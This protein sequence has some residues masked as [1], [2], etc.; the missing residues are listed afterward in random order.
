MDGSSGWRTAAVI[1]TQL[2]STMSGAAVAV[3]AM[4]ASPELLQFELNKAYERLKM[5]WNASADLPCM[6]G[7]IAMTGIAMSCA[8]TNFCKPVRD[9]QTAATHAMEC[10][11]LRVAETLSVLHVRPPVGTTPWDVDAY[12]KDGTWEVVD[13]CLLFAPNVSVAWINW[14]RA[15]GVRV[16]VPPERG[17]FMPRWTCEFEW[18]GGP[19]GGPPL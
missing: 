4:T 6:H 9:E 12:T 10:L 19:V 14:R 11:T 8:Y 18:T 17:T 2:L 7:E 1:T 13:K 5:S 15:A 16:L 3:S